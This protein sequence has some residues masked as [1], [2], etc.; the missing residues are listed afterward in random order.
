MESIETTEQADSCARILAKMTGILGQ[1]LAAEDRSL[2]PRMMASSDPSVAKT[3]RQFADEM[4]DLASVY[5]S[6]EVN[7]R[8]G[9]AIL[10]APQSFREAASTVLNALAIR[11]K[12]EN[13][14]LY[15]LAE[16]MLTPPS[17]SAA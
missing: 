13:E 8:T 6:F 9:K 7:W 4:G 11:I 15:P 17:M 10:A 14:V 3:A 1:H 5:Q 2:Y 16:S 12:R